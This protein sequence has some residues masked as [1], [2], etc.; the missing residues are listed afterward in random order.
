LQPGLQYSRRKFLAALTCGRGLRYAILLNAALL[1]PAVCL[2]HLS[3]QSIIA[4]HTPS[5]VRTPPGLAQLFA[6]G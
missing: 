1:P 4:K 5:F 2:L 3:A 6:L